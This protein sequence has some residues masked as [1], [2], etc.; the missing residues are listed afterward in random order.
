LVRQ[1]FLTA[2]VRDIACTS[3]VVRVT[4]REHMARLG[5]A[6]LFV[7]VS[8]TSSFPLSRRELCLSAG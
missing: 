4:Q 5:S 2:N 3:G 7:F 1:V 6:S 8:I